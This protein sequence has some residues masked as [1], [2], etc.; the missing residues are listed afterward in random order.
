MPCE[1]HEKQPR[2]KIAKNRRGGQLQEGL[3]AT[4]SNFINCNDFYKIIFPFHLCDSDTFYIIMSFNACKI[5]YIRIILGYAI[6]S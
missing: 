4:V 3:Q 6:F 2:S 5:F 1:C